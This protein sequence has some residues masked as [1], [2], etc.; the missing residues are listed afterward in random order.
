[1]TSFVP[2]DCTVQQMQALLSSA[3]APRPIAFA[4]TIDA[5]GNPNLSPFSF[6]N[7]FS[8]NPPILIFSPAR[9]VRDNTTKHTLQNVQDV[10]EVVINVVHYGMI[11][12]MS[13]SS[14][15]YAKGVNEF[16][17]SGLTMLKSELVR[18]FRVAESPIQMEC[19][20]IEIKPLGQDKGA[21][22]LVICKVLKLHVSDE[23]LNIKGEIDQEKLDLVARGGG[24]YYIR[25]KDGFLEI[26]KPLRTLGIGIDALPEELRNSTI[27][28]G[29]DLGLLGNV[30]ALPTQNEIDDFCKNQEHKSLKT[31]KELHQ[32]AQ[33]YLRE[34]QVQKA[35]CILLK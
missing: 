4:S 22:N 15:E 19:K 10:P 8:S 3:V 13:L 1:M 31:K 2:K 25:A 35:W 32:K 5:E 18:P 6:Y 20:V 26:P 27:L 28:T 21:G 17:K 29:N 24:S 14:T 33:D 11:Q 9:R 34:G 12:Q 7:I 16:D 23:V 30:E